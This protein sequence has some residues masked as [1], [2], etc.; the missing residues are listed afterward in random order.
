LKIRE[1]T[2]YAGPISDVN[3]WPFNQKLCCCEQ[4]TR[5]NRKGAS[6]PYVIG[7]FVS[8]LWWIVFA[9]RS[10]TAARGKIVQWTLSARLNPRISFGRGDNAHPEGS[11]WLALGD[12][13]SRKNDNKQK[14]SCVILQ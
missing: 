12:R 7:R 14:K 1:Q 3:R 11:D 9:V 4:Q 8:V 10:A 5:E 6:N 13:G 2:K